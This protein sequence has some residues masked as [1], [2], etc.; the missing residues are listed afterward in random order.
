VT[1]RGDSYLI[2]N[3]TVVQGNPMTAEVLDDFADL[4]AWRAHRPDGAA[5]TAISITAAP[6]RTPVSAS[7]TVQIA[8]DASASGHYLETTIGATDLS[9]F[10]DLQLYISGSAAASSAAA[11][12]FYLELRLGSAASPVGSVANSWQRFIPLS[13]PGGWEAIP[14]SL[15]DLPAAVRNQVTT[16]RL[17]SVLGSAWSVALDRILAVHDDML[18]D[19]DA[20]IHARLATRLTFNGHAVPAELA[21]SS[22]APPAEPYLRISNYDVQPNLASSP[23]TARRTDYTGN[24]F[25]LRPPASVYDVYYAVEAIAADRPAATALLDFVLGELAPVSMVLSRDRPTRVEW[26]DAPGTAAP[27]VAAPPSD[28]PVLHFRLT[29]SR[30]ATAVAEPVVPVFNVVNVEVDQSVPA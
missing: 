27:P 17:T 20:A 10:S 19:A 3:T 7:G 21:P 28:H 1:E 6:P 8:A 15:A 16:I 22:I 26:I 2:R 4:T 25:A 24:G 13:Q 9:S 14:L 30:T 12:P 11:E 29:T 5:S 23:M 18:T